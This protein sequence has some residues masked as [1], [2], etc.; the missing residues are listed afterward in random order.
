M[1]CI[2]NTMDWLLWGSERDIIRLQEEG[3]VMAF[4]NVE[5]AREAQ[6]RRG[7]ARNFVDAAGDLLDNGMS[8]EDIR[9]ALDA[10]ITAHQVTHDVMD[11][12]GARG[13]R[14]VPH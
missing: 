6:Y 4:K 5:L 7:L 11:N 13:I 3:M 1:G 10:V 9:A 14:I 2:V 8:E 12:R